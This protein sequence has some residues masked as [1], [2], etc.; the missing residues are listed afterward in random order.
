MR[1]G[2]RLHADIV[3]VRHATKNGERH[4]LLFVDDYSKCIFLRLLK[5]V[6]EY[7]EQTK[8]FV[9]RLEARFGR[10]RVV[11]QFQSDSAPYFVNTIALK[12]FCDRKGIELTHSPPYSQALNS[13]RRGTGCPNGLRCYQSP[14][15]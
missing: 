5:Q 12:N 3:P 10:E 13:R 8:D 4:V 11:A 9:V 14:A 6:S 15:D 2:Y 7:L 1:P